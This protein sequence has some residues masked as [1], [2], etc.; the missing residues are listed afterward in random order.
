M[1]T[2]E[3]LLGKVD[4]LYPNAYALQQKLDWFNECEALI[5]LTILKEYDF[6][7]TQVQDNLN[8]IL[9][10]NISFEDIEYI[11]FN[12]RTL[13][14]YDLRSAGF[15]F[16]N[17]KLYLPNSG[18]LRLVY[19]KTHTP[20]QLA[21]YSGVAAINPPSVML[22][23]M[24]FIMGDT[25]DIDT[26]LNKTR[27]V[28]TQIQGNTFYTLPNTLVYENAANALIKRALVYTTAAKP[29]FD[30]VYIE[31]IFA[32]MDYHNRDYEG[33]NINAQ[34]YNDTLNQLKNQAKSQQPLNANSVT[35]NLW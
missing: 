24:P 13:Q 2:V 22:S 10:D 1:A 7:E 33:Y 27:F 34:R 26:A 25:V 8:V 18:R 31:Y 11:Y 28:I 3:E 6:I 35:K 29:P 20:Y 16:D 30:R 4:L 32:Q 15:G 21:E 12:N 17:N 23:Y 14:K 5:R 19:L 9:P